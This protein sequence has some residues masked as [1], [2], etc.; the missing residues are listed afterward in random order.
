MQRLT[1][2]G[3]GQDAESRPE[4]AGGRQEPVASAGP[5]YVEAVL[6]GRKRR[7]SAEATARGA[8]EQERN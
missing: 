1:H 3:A 8:G 2:P 5:S 7:V 4:A 6:F